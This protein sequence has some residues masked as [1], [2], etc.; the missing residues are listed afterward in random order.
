MGDLYTKGEDVLQPR[1]RR[2]W[3]LSRCGRSGCGCDVGIVS[4]V[5]L[6]QWMAL[7]NEEDVVSYLDVWVGL[8]G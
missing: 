3:T 7:R 8:R 5:G 4:E 2:P 6:G 1:P